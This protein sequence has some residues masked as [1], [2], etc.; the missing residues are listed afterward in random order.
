LVKVSA[1]DAKSPPY[2]TQ[3]FE[4]DG[5]VTNIVETSDGVFTLCQLI[6]GQWVDGRKFLVPQRGSSWVQ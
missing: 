4:F 2:F 5:H 3:A 1:D 6:E